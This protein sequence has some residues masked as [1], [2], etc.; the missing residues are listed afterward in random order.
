MK[1]RINSKAKGRSFEQSVAS[2][3][4]AV[5]DAPELLGAFKEA[6]TAKDLRE[7]QKRSLVRRGRQGEGATEPDVIVS[8]TKLWLECQN[9]S[10]AASCPLKKLEQAERDTKYV[11]SDRYEVA[12]CHVTGE[13]KSTATMRL[14]TFL[15]LFKL[16]KEYKKIPITINYSDFLILLSK[17]PKEY[18]S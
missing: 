16:L 13:R 3:M 10:R 15:K 12:L 4:R 7:L 5:F 14:G 8:G 17:L 2:D 6:K 1:K 9:A 11:G 18:L